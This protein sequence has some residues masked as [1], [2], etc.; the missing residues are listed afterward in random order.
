MLTCFKMVVREKDSLPTIREQFLFLKFDLFCFFIES[1]LDLLC[2]DDRGPPRVASLCG[3]LSTAWSVLCDRSRSTL[4]V[5]SLKYA[6]VSDL[7]ISPFSELL[8]LLTSSQCRNFSVCRT[9]LNQQ[10]EDRDLDAF[11]FKLA[12]P[13]V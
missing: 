12:N 4:V 7:S 6:K 10:K 5:F 11:N 3:S 8:A 9:E 1:L 2:P 13:K